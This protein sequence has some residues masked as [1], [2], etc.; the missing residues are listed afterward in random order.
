MASFT[1][2]SFGDIISLSLIV[3][4]LIKALDDIQGSSN[5]YRE[6]IRELG[7]LDRV[8]MEVELLSK[9]CEPTIEMNALS[10]TGRRIIDNCR[11]DVASFLDKI[12]KY[13]PYLAANSS[14]SRVW[15]ASMK[16]R[17]RIVHSGELQKFR[18]GIN[19]NCNKLQTLLG[20]ANM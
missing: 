14:S 18:A 5:E 13:D 15:T 9:R 4:D 1:F 7:M 3:K 17:W 8:L 12:L 11:S 6:I 19:A 10:V 2:G 16:V 20:A